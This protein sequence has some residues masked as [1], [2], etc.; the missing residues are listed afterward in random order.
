MGGTRSEAAREGT[1]L[2]GNEYKLQSWRPAGEF[3][4]QGLF[5][6]QGLGV[7]EPGKSQSMRCMARGGRTV[8][9]EAPVW[10]RAFCRRE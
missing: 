1:Q 3:E 9:K 7:A 5:A 10:E 4:R 2:S 8:S 6:R